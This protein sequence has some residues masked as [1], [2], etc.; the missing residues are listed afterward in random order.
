MRHGR[1]HG[2]TGECG[3]AAPGLLGKFTDAPLP[4]LNQSLKIRWCWLAGQL[5][6]GEG[7]QVLKN[8]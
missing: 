6:G 2:G 5:L 1:S 3:L 4:Q 8:T 7:G